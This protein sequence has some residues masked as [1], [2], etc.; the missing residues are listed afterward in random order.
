SGVQ[1]VGGCCGLSP[2]HIEVLADLNK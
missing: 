1:I 2:G